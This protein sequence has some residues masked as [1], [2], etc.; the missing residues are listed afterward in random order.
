[1]STAHGVG[2]FRHAL[3]SGKGV[4]HQSWMIRIRRR[5]VTWRANG[6]G[7]LEPM[8]LGPDIFKHEGYCGIDYKRVSTHLLEGGKLG[9]RNFC[10][11]SR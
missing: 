2:A 5:D 1:M 11:G 8:K 9:I 3:E 7:S 10:A 6:T 4:A